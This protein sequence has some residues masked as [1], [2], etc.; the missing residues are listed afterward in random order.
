LTGAVEQAGTTA[1][2]LQAIT[3]KALLT[4][5]ATVVNRKCLD[6]SVEHQFHAA[7]ISQPAHQRAVRLR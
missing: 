1:T 5:E 2:T 7:A 3:A 6:A 4:N